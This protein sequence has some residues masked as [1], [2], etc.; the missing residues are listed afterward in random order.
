MLAAH[1]APPQVDKRAACLSKTLANMLSSQGAMRCLRRWWRT[2]ACL[3]QLVCLTA[4]RAA[5]GFTETAL[6]EVRFE[7]ISTPVLEQERAAVLN[8]AAV[9]R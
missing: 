3:L 2:R 5:G 7:E 8:A 4:G 1:A 9:R 6:G